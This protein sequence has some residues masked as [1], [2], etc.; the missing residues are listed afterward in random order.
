MWREYSFEVFVDD[1]EPLGKVYDYA[2][3]EEREAAQSSAREIL[4]CRYWTIDS[5][6]EEMLKGDLIFHLK[7]FESENIY[8]FSK[9][10]NLI[11]MINSDNILTELFSTFYKNND[12]V[13]M[14]LSECETFY[15]PVISEAKKQEII[16][17]A[18]S[19]TSKKDN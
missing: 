1:D 18:L 2:G 11:V 12:G 4:D 9:T 16:S 15:I 6:L 14:E 10:G 7:A 3:Y 17:E 8:T 13:A 5:K 19:N